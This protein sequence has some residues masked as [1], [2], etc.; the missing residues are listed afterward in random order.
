MIC[1]LFI[2]TKDENQAEWSEAEAQEKVQDWANV[3]IAFFFGIGEAFVGSL[4]ERLRYRFP[5]FFSGNETSAEEERAV[6]DRITEV[7]TAWVG[8]KISTI[9]PGL[10]YSEIAGM[11][12]FEFFTLL[13]GGTKTGTNRDDR[14]CR[15]KTSPASANSHG[16][17]WL[18]ESP[19]SKTAGLETKRK[20]CRQWLTR[21]TP[22][23]TCYLFQAATAAEFLILRC[24]I[25]GSCTTCLAAGRL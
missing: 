16:S 7:E 21:K 25:T 10:I 8:L 6:Y 11:D 24:G 2:C 5:E 1:T 23:V 19:G 20:L 18:E 22:A 14:S 3:D 9:S 12:I 4:Y 17:T 13:L 15:F